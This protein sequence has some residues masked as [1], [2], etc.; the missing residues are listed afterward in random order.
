MYQNLK[1]AIWMDAIVKEEIE[2]KP[3][4]VARIKDKG[5]IN[6]TVNEKKDKEKRKM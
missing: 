1:N 5:T 2:S 6:K 4:R 3:R